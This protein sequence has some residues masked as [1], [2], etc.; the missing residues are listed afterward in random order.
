MLGWM[1]FVGFSTVC[2]AM[3]AWEFVDLDVAE[4]T[5][6]RMSIALGS[7]VLAIVVVWDE[8]GVPLTS[9]LDLLL[10]DPG[11]TIHNLTIIVIVMV[12]GLMYYAF[13]SGIG[14]VIGLFVRRW[15]KKRISR[16]EAI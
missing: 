14:G 5:S 12:V 1:W 10:P 8:I 9:Y 15:N 16:E 13:L 6:D 4:A 2:I 7:V 3:I 11:K